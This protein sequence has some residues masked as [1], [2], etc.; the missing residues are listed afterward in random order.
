MGMGGRAREGPNGG[1]R[2]GVSMWLMMLDAPRQRIRRDFDAQV[3]G[4]VDLG[5]C[6]G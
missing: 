3:L 2:E 6:I 4:F 1:G 5:Y